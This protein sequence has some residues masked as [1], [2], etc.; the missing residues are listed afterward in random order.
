MREQ[1][2]LDHLWSEFISAAIALGFC[3]AVG[4]LLALLHSGWL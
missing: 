3:T 4:G 2:T 1:T